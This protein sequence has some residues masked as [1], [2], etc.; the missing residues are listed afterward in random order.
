M[1]CQVKDREIGILPARPAGVPGLGRLIS[2][3]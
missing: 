3:A 2:E 1:T